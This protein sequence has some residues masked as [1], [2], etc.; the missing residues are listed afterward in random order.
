MIG[1][2]NTTHNVRSSRIVFSAALA[3]AVFIFA[4]LRVNRLTD[5]VGDIKRLLGNMPALNTLSDNRSRNEVDDKKRILGRKRA[6]GNT[7]MLSDSTAMLTLLVGPHKTGS[8]SIQSLLLELRNTLATDGILLCDKF[9]GRY[10]G[11][12]RFDDLKYGADL[13]F[14]LQNGV[15]KKNADVLHTCVTNP[16]FS[17][18]IFASEELDRLHAGM[19]GMNSLKSAKPFVQAIITM[20]NITDWVLSLYHQIGGNH[21]FSAWV[22]WEIRSN[23]FQAGSLNPYHVS[24]QY[25][26][27]GIPVIEINFMDVDFLFCSAIASSSSCKKIRDHSVKV[28]HLNNK[29]ALHHNENQCANRK[30]IDALEF[31]LSTKYN[32]PLGLNWSKLICD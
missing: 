20:R 4:V 1:E 5:E 8:C 29:E 3:I 14:D 32:V 7:S 10:N 13:A 30:T 11:S 9:E 12:K 18:V 24:K 22:Q 16:N 27:S 26:E 25:A 21:N 6:M 15:L 28:S 31:V 23:F 17:Q 2:E 19:T